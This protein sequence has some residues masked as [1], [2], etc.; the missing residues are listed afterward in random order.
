[1]I[2][3]TQIT[4]KESIIVESQK[5]DTKAVQFSHKKETAFCVTWKAFPNYTINKP[6]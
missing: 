2:R 5:E 3:V 4:A 1:M 6:S